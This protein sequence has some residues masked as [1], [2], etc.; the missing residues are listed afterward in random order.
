M[1]INEAVNRVAN[2]SRIKHKKHKEIDLSII[3]QGRK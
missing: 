1:Q 2:N 3:V